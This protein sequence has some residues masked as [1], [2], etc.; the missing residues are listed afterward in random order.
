MKRLYKLL[1]TLT[2]CLGLFV[3]VSVNAQA[4]TISSVSAV[5]SNGKITVS[6]TAEEGTLACAV[7]V[8]DSTGSTLL[9]METCEVNADNSFRYQMSKTYDKGTY[10]V[11]VAD[12]D[13]GSYKSTTVTVTEATAAATTTV[14]SPKTSEMTPWHLVV[15]AMLLLGV[16]PILRRRCH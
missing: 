4:K 7:F 3:A 14:K 15:A 1:F 10:V 13:G 6:G 12:Y 2:L 8:Y 16:A 9:D 11:K 5:N